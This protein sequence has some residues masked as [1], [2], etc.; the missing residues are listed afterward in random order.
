MRLVETNWNPDNRQL[1]Q[2]GVICLLALPLVGWL[3]FGIHAIVGWLAAVGLAMA[4]LGIV[5]PR[6]MK[7]I[8]VALMIVATPI[9]MVF[10]EFAMLLVFFGVFLPIGLIFRLAKRDA[11][12]L[13][14]DRQQKT[15]WQTKRQP[16]NLASYYRQ[17]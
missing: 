7:P 9:G 8:F 15:Y 3:W 13:K 5:L 4:V 6:A 2:F 16:R 1:R 14:L 11:L 12:Q 17:S 10:G